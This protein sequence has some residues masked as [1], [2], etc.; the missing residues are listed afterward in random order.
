MRPEAP[1]LPLWST[2]F[3]RSMRAD[4]NVAG[5]CRAVG[6]NRK[7]AY[8]WREKSAKFS[9]EWDKAVSKAG[10]N[11]EAAA[12]KRALASSDTL[13]L[14]LLRQERRREGS[15]KPG[16]NRLAM[17]ELL[18]E[19]GKEIDPA[20]RQMARSLADALDLDPSNAQMWRTY[21]DLVEHIR[22]D[23]PDDDG[24]GEL[25]EIRGAAEVGSLAAY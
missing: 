6:I 4:G 25:E 21:K 15:L 9:A 7:T 14:D 2:G 12:R 5:A 24:D 18:A 11:L 8:R 17:E 20:T 10:E 1:V 13:L 19:T 16:P 22:E 23:E 3:L